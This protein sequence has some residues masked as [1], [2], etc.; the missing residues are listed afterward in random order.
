MNNKKDNS[1]IIRLRLNLFY[2]VFVTDFIGSII[3]H[4]AWQIKRNQDF[5]LTIQHW[6]TN[7][8]FALLKILEN[9]KPTLWNA[10][11]KLDKVV[12]RLYKF[13]WKSLSNFLGLLYFRLACFFCVLFSYTFPY[14]HAD[15]SHSCPMGRCAI[16]APVLC[17]YSI[18]TP[19]KIK[20]T[21]LPTFQNQESSTPVPR[22]RHTPVRTDRIF[23]FLNCPRD[24]ASELWWSPDRNRWA[25]GW[26]PLSIL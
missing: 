8:D 26:S 12:F 18:R 22:L 4:F 21:L 19:F 5:H 3:A 23:P 17:R 10:P 15:L 6:Y 13:F 20:R 11:Q 1:T 2:Y 16:S 14:R 24:E 9:V 25:S 7:E